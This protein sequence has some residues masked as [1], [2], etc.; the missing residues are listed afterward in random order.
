MTFHTLALAAAL[1]GAA[2][3]AQAAT[4]ARI[5]V[6]LWSVKDEIKQD[7]EGTMG[8]L[9]ALGFDGV[10]FAGEFGPYKDNAAGLKAFMDQHKLASAGATCIT[11]RSP[12]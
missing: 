9:A 6:Q 3:L 8:K 1:L 4:T 12:P 10:E 11:P 5:G 2:I 7:F